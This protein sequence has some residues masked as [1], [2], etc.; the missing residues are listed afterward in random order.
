MLLA[1]LPS[2]AAPDVGLSSCACW[3]ADAG[4]DGSPCSQAV[5]SVTGGRR[6][7]PGTSDDD[8]LYGDNA[9][10]AGAYVQAAVARRVTLTA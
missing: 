2:G 3:L 8:L 5:P 1:L 10:V 6:P 4:P 9:V 7:E